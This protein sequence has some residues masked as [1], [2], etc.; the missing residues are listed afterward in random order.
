MV[1]SHPKM[2]K[3]STIGEAEIQQ[4]FEDSLLASHDVLQWR[5]V[6]GEDILTPNTK[7]IVVMKP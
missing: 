1:A 4:L 6:K 3:T 2:V 7:E 5:S